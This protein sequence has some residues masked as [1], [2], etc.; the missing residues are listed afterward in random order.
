ML[1]LDAAA[2][3]LASTQHGVLT[4]TQLLDLGVPPHQLD[5]RVAAG[6]LRRVQPAVFVV[7]GAPDTWEQRLLAAC[8]SASPGAVASH[9]SAARLLKL[10][11]V[12]TSQIHVLMGG[13]RRARLL[14]G[15]VHRTRVLGPADTVVRQGI[16]V[17]RPERTIVDCAAV[18]PF[19]VAASMVEGAVHDGLTTI[20][21]TWAYLS[22]YGGRGVRGSATVRA[23]LRERGTGDGPTES[24]LEDR[25]IAAIRRAGLP[26]PRRQI[27]FRSRGQNL[28]IDLGYPEARLAIEID[29]ARWHSDSVRYRADREKWNE[30]TRRG[31]ALLI[32]TEFD[33]HERPEGVGTDISRLLR[34]RTSPVRVA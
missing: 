3:H 8:W 17:T 5:R 2:H 6:L 1:S 25:A 4:R 28:R 26:T 23:V 9:R 20:D 21:A 29:S 33:L 10:R 22:R 34:A 15:T 11:N 16:P 13:T 27:P 19:D 12:T 24:G 14:Q 31:W 30:L 18:V 7:A 32:V